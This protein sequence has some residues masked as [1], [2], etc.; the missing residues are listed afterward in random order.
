[1]RL[2]ES[3]NSCFTPEE[4]S[5]IR[6]RIVISPL[7]GPDQEREFPRFFEAL[8]RSAELY[9]SILFR[10]VKIVDFDIKQDHVTI[11]D[12]EGRESKIAR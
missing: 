9:S 7:P 10:G 2:D 1:M 6:K 3:L 12:K 8:R 5:R 11:R 4:V